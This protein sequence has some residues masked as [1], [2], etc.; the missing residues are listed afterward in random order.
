MLSLTEGVEAQA[1]LIGADGAVELDPIAPV[2]VDDPLVILPGHP[3]GDEAL[4]L[5]QA[6]HDALLDQLGPLVDHGDQGREHLVHR[7]VEFGLAGVA[8]DHPLHQLVEI[9]VFGS[10]S[11]YLFPPLQSQGSAPP[12]TAGSS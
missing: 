9:R 4:G 2:H 12:G 8:G 5:H 3:E 11:S 1:T 7:L 10:L 6:V